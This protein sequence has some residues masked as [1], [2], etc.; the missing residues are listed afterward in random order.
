VTRQRAV[1]LCGYDDGRR[2]TP[3]P[4]CPNVG[5]HT[6]E[7]PG[8]LQWFDWAEEMAKTHEQRQC[9]GCERWS[10][11]EPIGSSVPEEKTDG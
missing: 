7:P 3:N 8:Y 10:I 4:E 6:P 9:P 1:Y 5:Q 2:V 11:W